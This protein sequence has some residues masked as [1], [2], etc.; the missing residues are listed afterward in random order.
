A[1]DDSLVKMHDDGEL[2]SILERWGLWDARQNDIARVDAEALSGPAEGPR[3][4]RLVEAMLF[5]EGAAVTIGLS[6]AAFALALPGGLLLALARL[7]RQGPL[8]WLASA[9]VE[10][11]RGTPLLLQLYVLYFALAPLVRLG[12]LTAAVLGLA[13][14][15]AA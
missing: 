4:L 12:A 8:R 6:V 3:K 14:N 1:I 13:M 2:R 5:L 9:Y 10:V 7:G 11:F 15:Y